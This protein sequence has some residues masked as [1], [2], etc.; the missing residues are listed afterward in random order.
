MSEERTVLDIQLEEAMEKVM[1]DPQLRV[2]FWHIITSF[3]HVFDPG[4]THNAAAY[5]LLAKKQAGLGILEW[6]KQVSPRGVFLA[7]SEYN[8]LANEQGGDDNG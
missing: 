3:L 7:E 6:M 1:G 5:S 8:N 2:L 4:Y